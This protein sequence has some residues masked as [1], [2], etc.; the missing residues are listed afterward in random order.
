VCACVRVCVRAFVRVCMVETVSEAAL[1]CMPSSSSSS[2]GGCARSSNT[3]KRST[4]AAIVRM[5]HAAQ[6]NT[7]AMVG[8]MSYDT[9]AREWYGGMLMPEVRM[10]EGSIPTV[11]V[12]RLATHECAW[13]DVLHASKC[14]QERE[15]YAS[16]RAR[17]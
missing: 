13:A 14:A 3:L 8:V 16:V 4:A 5:A 7:T 17:K 15:T 11:S 9:R 2:S 12:V 10:P 6:R 1:T